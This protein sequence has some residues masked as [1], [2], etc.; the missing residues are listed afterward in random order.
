MK[1]G[2][3][4]KR[5]L[6]DTG[7]KQSALA[8]Y[9]GRS[10][11]T[12]AQ[13]I[14]NDSL[15][16]GLSLL[17]AAI[18]LKINP[19]LL[20]FDARSEYTK[21]SSKLIGENKIPVLDWSLKEI[22]PSKKITAP[23]P[24]SIGSYALVVSD[25]TMCNMSAFSPTFP[26]KTIV[27]VDPEVDYKNGSIVIAQHSVEKVNLM[28]QYYDVGLSPRLRPL[29]IGSDEPYSAEYFDIVGVVVASINLI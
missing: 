17:K 26:P 5:R 23:I 8:E 22:N 4:I 10:R 28:R 12:I 27:I 9:V 29:N 18:F 2:D 11:Q 3:R 25:D 16:D 21:E 20:C 13:W 6:T 14:S 24:T 1:I 7:A 15:P 19:Y